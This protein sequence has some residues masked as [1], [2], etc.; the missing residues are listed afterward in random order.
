MRGNK[1]DTKAVHKLHML[2]TEPEKFPALVWV[3]FRNNKGITTVPGEF[4]QLFT[5]RRT[6]HQASKE[7]DEE[8]EK[9]VISVQDAING[10]VV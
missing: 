5:Q 1:I 2:L 10:N 7:T 8:R 9:S 4:V 3:D 6:K